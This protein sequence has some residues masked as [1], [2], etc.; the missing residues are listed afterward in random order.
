MTASI[1]QG[2]WYLASYPKSGNT[3]CRVFITELQRLASLAESE[4]LNLNLDLQTGTIASS[5]HWLNDQ[6]G[7]NSCD[8]SFAELDPLRGRA[9]AS[10]L[11]YS[12]RER[13]HKVHD[14]FVSPD[15]KARPVVSTQG[16]QGAVY[17][18]RHPADVVVSLS[19]FFSWDLSQCVESLL[20]PQ[21]ALVPSERFGDNQVRQHMGRWDQHVDSWLQQKQIPLLAI[22]YED[23]LANGVET[24]TAL[25]KFLGLPD[26]GALIKN[27][28]NNTS[29]D[30]LRT[31][32]DE[33]GGFVEKPEGCER[34]F[35]S[36][37]TGEGAEQLTLE[38]RR[39]LA[40]AFKRG[41]DRFGYE[42]PDG[43]AA[44]ADLH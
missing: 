29:I 3:W 14:A 30:R 22:R 23:M 31:M 7:I 19:H 38:Q 41:M 42:G 1:N 24:F 4:K 8:L 40:S 27:A 34:F 16:C 28:I 43:A 18:V 10:A 5:R 35:R 13:F 21:A 17:I 37:R 26:D 25:A 9:G 2:Y 36:G 33:L 11:L 12:E 39:R 15:S 32:E 44:K 6:L 20:N